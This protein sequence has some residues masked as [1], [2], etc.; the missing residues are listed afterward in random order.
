MSIQKNKTTSKSESKT[1][2]PKAKDLSE[3]KE[4]LTKEMDELME[5][6]DEVLEENA[7]EFIKAYV[8]RGGQI[9]LLTFGVCELLRHVSTTLGTVG[10]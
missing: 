6:I 10:A 9:V 7:A 3:K 8:Q 4:E 1:S 5:E 2:T